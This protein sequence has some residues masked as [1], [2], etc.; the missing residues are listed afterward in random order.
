MHSRDP[1]R[2]GPGHRH[3]ALRYHPTTAVGSVG[4]GARRG[5]IARPLGCDVRVTL[6]AVI[7]LFGCH[8]G[9]PIRT[10]SCVSEVPWVTVEFVED[11][12]VP[13]ECEALGPVR[14]ES[15][16]VAHRW[17]RAENGSVECAILD[18]KRATQARGGNLVAGRYVEQL[19][20]DVWGSPVSIEGSAYRCADLS[21]GE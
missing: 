6:I 14:G 16:D 13:S 2:S 17:W 19:Y 1:L 4:R 3:P 15:G 20:V 9:P 12:A 11:G 7:A 8:S 10:A 18:L 5:L 21:A